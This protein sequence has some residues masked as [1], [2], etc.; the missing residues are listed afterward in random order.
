MYGK[1]HRPILQ[2]INDSREIFHGFLPFTYS[3]TLTRETQEF[4]GTGNHVK[5]T[6]RRD[7]TGRVADDGRHVGVAQVNRTN[8]SHK[9][10]RT[11]NC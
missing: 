4:A 8:E 11:K 1:T 5:R 3:V 2:T 7:G 9:R 6:D 10:S